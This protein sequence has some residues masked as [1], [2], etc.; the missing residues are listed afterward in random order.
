MEHTHTHEADVAFADL[1]LYEA[2]TSVAADVDV[3]VASHAE[4][5]ER[6]TTKRLDADSRTDLA[7]DLLAAAA[8]LQA[9]AVQV[10]S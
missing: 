4:L 8:R 9:L 6:L 1:P 7:A 5:L 10:L 2:A 3:L